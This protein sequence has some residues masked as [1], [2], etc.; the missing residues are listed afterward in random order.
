MSSDTS[1]CPIS[2]LNELGTKISVKYIFSEKT[3]GDRFECT[4]SMEKDETN[5]IYIATGAR[6]Q[7]AKENAADKMV[8]LLKLLSPIVPMNKFDEIELIPC[9][10]QYVDKLDQC[11]IGIRLYEI[12][13][14]TLYL[15][16]D[17]NEKEYTIFDKQ[18]F[19]NE[20]HVLCPPE[21]IDNPVRYTDWSQGPIC[22]A[23][24]NY[25]RRRVICI[26][27]Q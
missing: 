7:I 6:K 24:K 14:Q 12:T 20:L 11:D 25:I 16:I 17:K 13:M 21:L 23:Q 15:L 27:N 1:C 5:F 22:I 4:I 2:Q 8:K 26:M 18:M 19:E 3:I 9:D 10:Y